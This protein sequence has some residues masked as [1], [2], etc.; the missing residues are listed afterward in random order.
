[1]ILLLETDRHRGLGEDDAAERLS[2]FGPNVLPAAT[3]AGPL[4][5][6]LSQFRHPLIY[7]LMAAAVVAFGLD[8][9]ID[10]ALILG[11]VLINTVVGF[12]QESKAEA[13]LEG[14]RSMRSEEHTSELQSREN[15]VCRLLRE[16]KN[17]RM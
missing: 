11:V 12:V 7:V 4:R 10:A 16:K 3:R 1:P 17:S 9:H 8:E 5:R 13:A 6:L 15:L 14:L 2:R